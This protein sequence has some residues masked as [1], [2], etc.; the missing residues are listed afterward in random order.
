MDQI[1]LTQLLRNPY[2]FFTIWSLIC[3]LLTPWIFK[4]VNTLFIFCIVAPLG[5][6]FTRF[7]PGYVKI[8][9]N[10]YLPPTAKMD[11]LLHWLPLILLILYYIFFRI[12][13]TYQ[14]VIG[15]LL[16]FLIY[17]LKYDL[18][19]VYDVLKLH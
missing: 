8:D 10:T 18:F 5:T 3:F 12:P 9:D 11:F 15:A 7:N 6:F 14:N 4:Y 16:L 13:W 1:S 17:L 19:V 2:R